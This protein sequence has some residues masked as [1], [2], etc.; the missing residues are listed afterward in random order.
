MRKAGA[1]IHTCHWAPG[2]SL[3]HWNKIELCSLQTNTPHIHLQGPSVSRGEPG[4]KRD[5]EQVIPRPF[6]TPSFLH[7]SSPFTSH[8]LGPSQLSHPHLGLPIHLTLT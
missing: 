6:A 4:K 8:S 3:P 5:K 1:D 7:Y 2:P